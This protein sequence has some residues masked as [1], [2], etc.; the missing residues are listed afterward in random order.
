MSLLEKILF[1]DNRRE[2]DFYVDDDPTFKYITLGLAGLFCLAMLSGELE[3]V[4]AEHVCEPTEIIIDEAP[5][6]D[7][8]SLSE[9]EI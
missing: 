5:K 4:E 7:V 6:A 1:I 8:P 3:E 9:L 2:S